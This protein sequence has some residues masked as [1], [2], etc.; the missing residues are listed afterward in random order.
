[1][2]KL[3]MFAACEKVLIDQDGSVSLVC[4]LAELKAEMPEPATKAIP[5]PAAAMRWA[6][7]SMWLKTETEDDEKEYEQRIA[8]IDPSGEATGIQATTPFKF[9]DKTIMRNIVTILGFPIH[10]SGRYV[11]R[12]WMQEKGHA[13]S[14]DPIAE[15]PIGVRLEQPK[16]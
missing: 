10:A 11:L 3:M 1:M 5:K 14:V 16:D 13:E 8:L 12:L 15:Y 6:A 7:F 2:P 4:L 9:G